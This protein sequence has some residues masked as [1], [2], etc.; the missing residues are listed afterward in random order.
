MLPLRM[1]L[2]GA[3]VALL[4]FTLPNTA[5]LL[6]VVIVLQTIALGTFWAP[7]M[8][9]LSEAAEATHLDQGLAAA[10]MNLAWAGGQ[11]AGSGAGG[12]IAKV[13]GDAVPML[14]ASALCGLTL[15]LLRPASR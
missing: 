11:I 4:F 7:A 10:L 6:G 15:V 3:A 1:G 14:A 2:A 5:L 8:A 13:S 9:M 12:A